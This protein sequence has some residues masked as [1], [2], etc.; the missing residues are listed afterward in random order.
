MFLRTIKH[1]H[2][3]FF[4]GL[5]VATL[6]AS[7]LTSSGAPAILLLA[8][9]AALGAPHGAL[10]LVLAYQAG[11][12][13]SY[14]K[15]LAFFVTYLAL[16]GLTALLWVTTPALALS[17]F[18]AL[19]AWHFGADWPSLQRELRFLAGAAVVSLPA[20]SHQPAVAELE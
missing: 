18:L 16:A 11:L 1:I 7:S 15:T 9:T 19:S 20:V 6:F 13:D 17:A 3:W 5:C 4:S 12:F 8:V 14:R 10:D 2:P